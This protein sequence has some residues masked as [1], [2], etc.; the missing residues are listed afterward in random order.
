MQ[1]YGMKDEKIKTLAVRLPEGFANEM[2]KLINVDGLF[3]SNSDILKYGARLVLL[4]TK[5]PK[6]IEELKKETVNRM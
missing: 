5:G 2:D 6:I 4:L 3:L 1:L